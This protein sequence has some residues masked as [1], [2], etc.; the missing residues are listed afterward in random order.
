MIQNWIE[1]QPQ[2]L[3]LD[4]L[5]VGREVETAYDGRIDLLGMNAEGGLVIMELKRDRTPR[6]VIAQVLDYASWISKF[7]TREVQNLADKYLPKR[8][9]IAFQERFDA[10]LPET[11]NQ[12]H[13]MLI[14]ASAFDPSSHRIVRYLSE[15]H[16]LAINTAFFTVFEESA[17]PFLTTDWL[18]D[19]AEV[20]ERS[21][22]KTRATTSPE[23]LVQLAGEQK[24]SELVQACRQ[25]ASLASEEAAVTYG[26]SFRYWFRGKMILGV[27]VAGGRRRSPGVMLDVWMSVPKLAELL[28][29]AAKEMHAAL[30]KD[31]DTTDS[32]VTES[33]V[34]LKTPQEAQRLVDLMRT[35]IGQSKKAESTAA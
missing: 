7:S 28:P 34:R 18:L 1:K 35:W 13:S 21:E 5:I 19:Q 3:G 10:T 2:L 14:I 9:D 33:V 6:E 23:A 31:F 22:A 20:T 16:E 11:L 29:V 27:N 24:I 26:G 4:L 17:Q 15:E 12:S 25:M 32:G 30:K 8:L